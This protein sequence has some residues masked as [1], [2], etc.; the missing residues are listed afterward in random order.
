M[1]DTRQESIEKL[2]EL[3]KDID[4]AM[5]TT[6]DGGVLRSRPMQTQDFEFD[7]DLWFFTSSET[8]KAEEIERDNR[9]NV[10]YGAPEDNKYVSV[11]GRG[12]I[13][14]DQE[15]IDEYWNDIL[16]AWFPE[17]KDSPDLVLLKVEVEQAE[18]WDAPSSK[19]AQAL[20]FLKALATG[21]RADVGENEKINL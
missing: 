6:N 9:V 4:F 20:G 21:E 18:Y 1:A 13:V 8:H 7:G 19:V 2:N 16:K 3:I 5:L 15:K 17:G 11:S 12:S 10:S 14:K